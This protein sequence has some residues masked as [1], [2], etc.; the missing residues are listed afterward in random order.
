MPPTIGIDLGRHRS[1]CALGVDDHQGLVPL[2]DAGDTGLW[3]R[4]SG[5]GRSERITDRILRLAGAEQTAAAET[6]QRVVEAM[7]PEL[8]FGEQLAGTPLVVVP[9]SFG[10][11]CRGAVHDGVGAVGLQLESH[12][13]VDRPIAALAG[14]LAGA[15][16]E[17]RT[18]LV[19][20]IDNDHGQLSFCAADLDHERLLVS[21]PL[22][23][24]ALD[25]PEDV[26]SRLTDALD[27]VARLA[28]G[29][30]DEPRV[31]TDGPA[32]S[33][34]PKVLLSGTRTHDVR[35]QALADLVLGQRSQP[36]TVGSETVGSETVGSVTVVG[37]E[38]APVLGLLH[39]DVF[40]SWSAC[41]PT[42][43]I[44]LDDV[45]LSTGY[46]YLRAGPTQHAEDAVL[47]GA[48]ASLGLA[49]AGQA[50]DL[51]AGSARG[52]AIQL[53]TD[54]GLSPRLRVFDDGRLLVLGAQ[55][56]RPVSF[57]V[58]WPA[59]TNSVH[60]VRIEA[61]GRRPVVLRSPDVSDVPAGAAGDP[62]TDRVRPR[63]GRPHRATVS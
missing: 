10:P 21:V 53:P 2:N 60:E 7:F 25:D 15:T 17:P 54:L 14:W 11:A 4:W 19:G 9:P 37:D 23:H 16:A 29:D 57:R 62:A 12:Q 13:L 8:A 48:T 36:E 22:S 49:R 61:I 43:A 31:L 51:V 30:V 55:G 20:L 45:T 38:T 52:Q 18:G 26:R 50:V 34:I 5:T 6:V 3:L 40:A 56:S 47:A 44:T 42:L 63:A 41:W 46:T 39:L 1:F 28:A 27:R 32:H 58:V 59:P 33:G 35:L 24:D